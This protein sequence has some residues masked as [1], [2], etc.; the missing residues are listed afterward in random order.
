MI[1]RL[2]KTRLDNG[3]FVAQALFGAP[4]RQGKCGQVGAAEIAQLDPFEVVP[5]ALIGVKVGGVARQLF[6]MHTPSGASAQEVFDGLAAMNRRPIPDDQQLA[7]DFAQ[8]DL[9]ETHD[10]RRAVGMILG[11]HVQ[12]PVGGNAADGG[13]VVVGERDPQQRRLAAG[14]PGAHDVWQQVEA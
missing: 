4:Q 1:A 2:S 14:R 9:E 7:A 11:L 13:E 5:D 8:Q 12:A 10:I 6:Q 3:A